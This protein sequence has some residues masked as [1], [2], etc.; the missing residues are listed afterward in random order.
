MADAPRTAAPAPDWHRFTTAAPDGLD[1][2]SDTALYGADIPTEVGLR[3]IGPV[4]AKRV[5]ELGCGAGHAS[6]G[7]ARQG[8]KAIAVDP[9][10]HQ[11]DLTRRAAEAADVKVELHEAVLAELA[12]VRADSI[13]L[14]FSSYALAEVAD[15]DRVF[16]QVHRV[17][18]PEAPL[19]F[20][21]PHPAFTLFDPRAPD[22]LRLARGYH[23]TSPISWKRDGDEVTDH[24]RTVSGVFTSLTRANFRVDTVLEPSSADSPGHSGHWTD[25]MES[26]PATII[27]R[28]RKQGA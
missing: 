3:L 12:F 24:P 22:P 7:F 18:K 19:V 23:D 5:L 28:A 25:V 20:S 27:Y 2:T 15:L 16:R 6:V 17:L 14:V 9:D 13:D 10:P 11:I 1:L 8:A 21:L 4:E 26:V